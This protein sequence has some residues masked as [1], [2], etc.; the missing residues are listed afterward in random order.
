MVIS[1]GLI[2]LIY[3]MEMALYNSLSRS[4]AM[5]YCGRHSINEK[6]LHVPPF[7]SAHCYWLPFLSSLPH[8]SWSNL[9]PQNSRASLPFLLRPK[10]LE[11]DFV[12]TVLRQ[13]C[14]CKAAN[15]PPE[16]ECEC[17]PSPLLNHPQEGTFQ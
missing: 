4:A 16:I 13:Y 7:L 11:S 9:A 10:N 5:I 14:I 12:A 17:P 6:T 15:D 8:N 3:K 1:S 2:L